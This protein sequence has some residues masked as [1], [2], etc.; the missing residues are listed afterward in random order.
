VYN[1]TIRPFNVGRLFLFGHEKSE[2][3]KIIFL[4]ENHNGAL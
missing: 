2:I 1:L 3:S 4:L